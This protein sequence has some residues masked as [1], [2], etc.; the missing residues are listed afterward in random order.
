[1]PVEPLELRKKARLGKIAVEY[2]HRVMRINRGNE[3]VAGVF[4]CL[5][6]P[7]SDVAGEAG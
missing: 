4:D 5:Q 1:M 7:R 3:P 2:P 6:M